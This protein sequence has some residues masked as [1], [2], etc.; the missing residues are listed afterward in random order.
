MCLLSGKAAARCLLMNF[1]D[2]N[3]LVSRKGSSQTASHEYSVMIMCLLSGK[4][5]IR[6][7]LMNTLIFGFVRTLRSHF[8]TSVSFLA[9]SPTT[10]L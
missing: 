9:F 2:D 3:V 8:V 6:L 10:S 5:A 4:G 7:Q 1:N